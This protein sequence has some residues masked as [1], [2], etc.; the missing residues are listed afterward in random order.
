VTS[1]AISLDV[2]HSEFESSAFLDYVRANVKRPFFVIPPSE[3]AESTNGRSSRSETRSSARQNPNRVGIAL[4]NLKGRLDSELARVLETKHRQTPHTHRRSHKSDKLHKSDKSPSPKPD[5][6]SALWGGSVD[7][8]FCF[9]GI[10]DRQEHFTALSS[11]GIEISAYL[12]L[13]CAGDGP[14]SWSSRR[15][16]VRRKGTEIE[17]PAVPPS[18]WETIRGYTD[19]TMIFAQ[20]DAPK[21]VEESWVV[22]EREIERIIHC[23]ES[24][25]SQFSNRQFTVLPT[26]NAETDLTVFRQFAAQHPSDI[27]NGLIAAL[28]E[29]HWR[30]AP[31]LPEPTIQDLYE[32]L[33]ERISHEI[34]RGTWHRQTVQFQQLVDTHYD[35]AFEF[36]YALKHWRLAEQSALIARETCLFY[37]SITNFHAAA[38]QHFDSITSQVNKRLSLGLPSSYFDWTKWSFTTEHANVTNLLGTVVRQ[39]L[40]FE[41]HLEQSSG[42]LWVLA[43][44]PVSRTVGQ[45]FRFF[46][47]PAMLDGASDWYSCN[48]RSDENERPRRPPTPAEVVK[49]GT[50]VSCLLPPLEERLAKEGHLYRAAAHWSDCVEYVS[51][52]FFQTGTQVHVVRRVV[53]GAPEFAYSLWF[54]NGIEVESNGDSVLFRPDKSLRVLAHG[55]QSLS[56]FTETLVLR[57]D[58]QNLTIAAANGKFILTRT[59]A[60][61][62]AENGLSRIVC[63][64]GRIG[65]RRD[66]LWTWVN[67]SGKGFQRVADSLRSTRHRCEFVTDYHKQITRMIR[68]DGVK[69]TCGDSKSR[70]IEFPNTLTIHHD[71]RSVC[72]FIQ[73]LPTIVIKDNEFTFAIDG[74][75]VRAAVD[76]ISVD[77]PD[78]AFRY[79]PAAVDLV[80]GREQ[81]V[82]TSRRMEL[83]SGEFAL[84][85]DASGS[86][87]VGYIVPDNTALPRKVPEVRSKWGKIQPLKDTFLEADQVSMIT[88]FRP[89]FFAIR[90]DLSA[91][92][93]LHESA[94]GSDFVAQDRTT[95]DSRGTTFVCTTLHHPDAPPRAFIQHEV[96]AKP[97]RQ[98]LLK[99]VHVPGPRS[100]K[101]QP[102]PD[103]STLVQ[104]GVTAHAALLGAFRE[105]REICETVKS[106]NESIYQEHLHPKPKPPPSEPRAP[107]QTPSP[108]LLVAQSEAALAPEAHEDYWESPE[109]QFVVAPDIASPLPQPPSPRMALFD[110]PRK[111]RKK[112]DD[113]APTAEDEFTAKGATPRPSPRQ[114][115]GRVYRTEVSQPATPHMVERVVDF[116]TVAVGEVG[117]A[118]VVLANPAAKP[119]R[120]TFGLPA[121]PL[122]KLETPPGT[123]PPGLKLT[124][125]LTVKADQPQ[126]IRSSFVWRTVDGECVIPIFARIVD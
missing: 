111:A 69:V 4:K 84:Y 81:A 116:G 123:I 19:E 35:T 42:V 67:A 118:S 80:V 62:F 94:V 93:F 5:R 8:I 70:R 110:A 115:S 99:T 124:A 126:M 54:A 100:R 87:R 49:S 95:E 85:A 73:S 106:E 11:I 89:R 16:S 39:S 119:L 82:F 7:I 6:S 27:V 68:E 86:Q 122:V 55:K 104:E 23:R 97:A 38:G 75:S 101:L 64:D 12:S 31:R 77:S 79:G 58:A 56:L 30:A 51:P 18:R 48:S 10:P 96:L 36:L 72:V 71:G 22:L 121:S 37:A 107:V 15:L 112:G 117:R 114:P 2:I 40:V 41:T 44:P 43:M 65:C 57:F 32:H 78:Y 92:E 26:A 47:M 108:R 88:V 45:P 66:G 103:L 14:L 17:L 13:V 25:L 74:T 28:A 83:L 21:T 91:T 113:P 24:F 53:Y 59:G 1:F 105:I 9:V 34:A 109:A 29:N 61:I 125:T 102:Q 20:V 3:L 52:Y 46:F 120:Y 63:A 60:V 90:T 98:T 76:H 50:G 33:F